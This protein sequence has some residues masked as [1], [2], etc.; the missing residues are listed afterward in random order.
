MSSKVVL[1]V[2][3]VEAWNDL[4]SLQ[5]MDIFSIHSPGAGQVY[6]AALEGCKPTPYPLDQRLLTLLRTEHLR[7]VGG[8]HIV[9]LGSPGA[10]HNANRQDR[11][12]DT[13][14][15]QN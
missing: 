6:R 7:K 11:A 5:D 15:Y 1:K 8:Q 9:H 3:Q 14:P 2:A 10:S 13:Y 4:G 12:I